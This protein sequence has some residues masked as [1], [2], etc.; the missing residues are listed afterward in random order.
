[1]VWILS[2]IQDVGVRVLQVSAAVQPWAVDSDVHVAPGA[3]SVWSP[4]EIALIVAPGRSRSDQAGVGLV[5]TSLV[6]VTAPPCGMPARSL[7]E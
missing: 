3:H 4:G 7:L 6:A 2:V 5:A 1:M